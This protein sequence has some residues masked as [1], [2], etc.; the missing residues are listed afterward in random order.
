MVVNILA[1][2][3][4]DLGGALSSERIALSLE[5][6]LL[7]L[8]AIFSVL[9]IIWL[10]LT[11]FKVFFYNEPN[12]NNV[13]EI[14]KIEQAPSVPVVEVQSSNV[15]VATSHNSDDAT[16]AAIIAAIS[17]HITNDPELSKEYSGGF[18]VVSFKR[19]RPKATWNN[20]NN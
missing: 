6:T 11:L 18:R 15:P 3:T 19:V 13:K 14:S 9:A 7:G 1:K 10:V 17:A 16:V 8:G 5:M 2:A 12:K 4:E 20:K